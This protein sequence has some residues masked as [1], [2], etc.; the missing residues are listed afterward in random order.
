MDPRA[1]LTELG[2]SAEDIN[3]MLSDEKQARLITATAKTHSEA[4]SERAAAA[5][6]KAETATFWEQKTQELQGSVNKLSAAEKRA[7]AAE[8]EAARVRAYN[9]SLADQGYDVPKE[10]YEGT[11]TSVVE[12]PKYMTQA[13]ID[14]RLRATAPDLV[15]LTALSNEYRSLY[16][17]DYLAIED[18][19]RAA[20]QAGKPLREFARVK[21]GFEAK[22]AEK[23]AAADQARIDKIVGEHEEAFKKTWAETHGSNDGLRVPLPSKFDKLTGTPGFKSDSW[24]SPEG[25][26][27]NRADRLK[28]FENSSIQ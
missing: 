11:G 17:E 9:K 16:G 4:K 6:E 18:D 14:Q 13:D 22:K 21:Y 26:A 25:R 2:Y 5:A 19:F 20:Q 23:S 27:Q 28:K 10:M 1:Y 24:K 3:A 8:A 7:A 12:P 15:S